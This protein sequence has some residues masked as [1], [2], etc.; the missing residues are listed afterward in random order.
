MLY[1]GG[2]FSRYCKAYF[3]IVGGAEKYEDAKLKKILGMAPHIRTQII[4]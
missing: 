2:H 4:G 3:D 1:K